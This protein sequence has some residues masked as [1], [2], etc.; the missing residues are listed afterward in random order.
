M[1]K[2][3][4]IP[5]LKA[6]LAQRMDQLGGQGVGMSDKTFDD[7]FMVPRS[8]SPADTE[9]LRS[10]VKAG[11][12]SFDGTRYTLIPSGPANHSGMNCRNALTDPNC[13][14]GGDDATARLLAENERLTL[15]V[16]RLKDDIRRRT[17]MF[18]SMTGTEVDFDPLANLDDIVLVLR[19][20]LSRTGLASRYE[21]FTLPGVVAEL[22]KDLSTAEAR[23]S[24]LPGGGDPAECAALLGLKAVKVEPGMLLAIRE[25]GPDSPVPP[26][27][28]KRMANALLSELTKRFG[29]MTYG[30][31]TVLAIPHGAALEAVHANG[32]VQ[33]N[34][35]PEGH[36]ARPTDVPKHVA[37]A[38]AEAAAAS[39][40]V[41]PEVVQ[42]R[43]KRRIRN[44]V[45]M[46]DIEI[47]SGQDL[48]RIA[49]IANP[50]TF[51]NTAETDYDFRSRL[52]RCLRSASSTD[53]DE[54]PFITP[55]VRAETKP[56]GQVLDWGDPEAFLADA[57][58]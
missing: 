58:G 7:I 51:R 56:V 44:V 2:I 12:A 26:S 37:R 35:L 13:G 53:A 10:M 39:Y 30:A 20:N 46:C 6:A 19:S 34:V 23:L 28:L 11:L 48:D 4:D 47:A 57:E 32:R 33:V 40:G 42:E 50:G 22:V 41:T 24:S 29:S 18:D 1:G 27:A 36:A 5:K 54:S 52:I 3:R 55:E 21:G 38:Y 45:P 9:Y 14:D 15:E 17:K 16:V 31:P 49:R 43:R 8:M 25:P